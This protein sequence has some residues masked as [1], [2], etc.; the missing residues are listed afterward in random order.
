[1]TRLIDRW[2]KE[3]QCNLCTFL[4]F[5]SLTDCGEAPRYGCLMSGSNL[6]SA[7]GAA[8]KRKDVCNSARP[9]LHPCSV[10]QEA[11][12]TTVCTCVAYTKKSNGAAIWVL[13]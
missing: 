4:L 6:A 3:V 12:R 10:K 11:T 1:M 9:S 13:A 5:G 2:A 7:D 8:E